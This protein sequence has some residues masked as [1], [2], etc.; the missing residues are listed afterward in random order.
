MRPVFLDPEKEKEFQREGYVVVDFMSVE[1][2]EELKNKFFELLPQSGG[3]I[4]ASDAG[5]DTNISYDFTFIDKFSHFTVI[6]TFFF[7]NCI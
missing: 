1:E 3:N 2:A 5:V 6:L 7:H 4:T